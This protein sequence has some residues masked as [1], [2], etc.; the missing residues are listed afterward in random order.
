MLMPTYTEE[1]GEKK[2]GKRVTMPVPPSIDSPYCPKC[3]RLLDKLCLCDGK[4]PE[5]PEGQLF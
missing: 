3:H 5:I 1:D 4:E 2:V